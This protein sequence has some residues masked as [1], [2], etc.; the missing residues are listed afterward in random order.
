MFGTLPLGHRSDKRWQLHSRGF[1][2][3]KWLRGDITL[4][5]LIS[6]RNFPLLLTQHLS[7][8]KPVAEA[9]APAYIS[10]STPLAS[11]A[12]LFTAC[13]LR[14][15]RGLKEEVSQTYAHSVPLSIVPS[16]ENPCLDAAGPVTGVLGCRPHPPFVVYQAYLSPSLV[17]Q[18]RGWGGGRG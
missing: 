7:P 14:K 3:F 12:L 15:P 17:G 10:A 11:R 16:S 9:P 8:F 4:T 13:L 2:S 18:K 1:E 6:R 5:D